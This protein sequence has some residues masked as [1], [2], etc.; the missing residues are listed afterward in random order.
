MCVAGLWLSM[1]VTAFVCALLSFRLVTNSD[2][3]QPSSYQNSLF[4]SCQVSVVPYKAK[5]N[6]DSS[7]TTH[8]TLVYWL[9]IVLGLGCIALVWFLCQG[10]GYAVLWKDP[11]PN[12]TTVHPHIG[13]Q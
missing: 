7:Y 12:P 9:G 2:L 1:T 3:L 5:N 13:N 11:D 8:L 10:D 4:Q 6:V